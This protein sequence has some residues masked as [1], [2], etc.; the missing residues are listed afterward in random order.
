MS[1]RSDIREH[2]GRCRHRPLGEEAGEEGD[3]VVD[4]VVAVVVV[5]PVGNNLDDIESPFARRWRHGEWMTFILLLFHPLHVEGGEVR[6]GGRR[7]LSQPRI[8]SLSR[9]FFF[10]RLTTTVP[11]T[12]V[13]RQKSRFLPHYCSHS[14]PLVAAT[15]AKGIFCIVHHKILCGY[16]FFAFLTMML[17]QE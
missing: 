17:S 14:V 1:K 6:G 5:P 4:H 3:D 7:L 9:S 15:T 10:S 2:C 8:I 13:P 11:S 16:S 12:I